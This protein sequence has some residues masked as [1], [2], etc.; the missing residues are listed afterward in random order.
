MASHEY[1]LSMGL[2]IVAS[3]IYGKFQAY[4]GLAPVDKS[5][6]AVEKY[7]LN[8]S[9]PVSVLKPFMWIHVQGNYNARCW[10]SWGSRFV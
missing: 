10:R 4:A 5:Y 6:A 7:L 1:L 3:I 8:K 2:L 9:N